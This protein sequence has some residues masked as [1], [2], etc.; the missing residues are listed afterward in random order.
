MTPNDKVILNDENERTSEPAAATSW[1]VSLRH[2]P[3]DAN[4]YHENLGQENQN[5]QTQI[6][7]TPSHLDALR[8]VPN[9]YQWLPKPWCSILPYKLTVAQFVKKFP[10][11]YGTQKIVTVF[12]K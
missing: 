5:R 11:F 7:S 1:T 4:E 2:F 8:V 6:L 3:E 10:A 9:N 12:S